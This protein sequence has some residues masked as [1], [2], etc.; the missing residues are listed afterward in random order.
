[1]LSTRNFNDPDVLEAKLKDLESWQ[2]FDVYDEVPNE[3]QKQGSTG[4][5]I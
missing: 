3:G 4:I 5:G 2:N 1:M